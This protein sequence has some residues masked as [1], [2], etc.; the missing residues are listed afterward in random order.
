MPLPFSTCPQVHPPESATVTS[1]ANLSKTKY[2][3]QEKGR[4]G[5]QLLLSIEGIPLEERARDFMQ[6]P[7]RCF[8]HGP[9]PDIRESELGLYD[10]CPP[11]NDP[12]HSFDFDGFVLCSSVRARVETLRDTPTDETNQE[13]EEEGRFCPAAVFFSSSRITDL[14]IRAVLVC[15]F[16]SR[17]CGQ[18]HSARGSMTAKRL[19][20]SASPVREQP[21][22]ARASISQSSSVDVTQ[23]NIPFAL[24]THLSSHSSFPPEQSEEL[25][26]GARCRCSRWRVPNPV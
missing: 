15:I 6:A 26:A 9:N 10:R 2:Q 22:P 3:I 25:P 18:E 19:L 13:L 5:R 4:A 16:A 8:R 24:G 14:L 21:S 11:I 23:D 20:M 1:I 7:I 17:S 12:I